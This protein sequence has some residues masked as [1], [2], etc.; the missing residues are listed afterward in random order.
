MT[1][2]INEDTGLFEATDSRGNIY[3]Q[4][5][6]DHY[7]CALP[8]GR[9]SYGRSAAEARVKAEKS[10]IQI[11][12]NISGKHA[13][14]IGRLAREED[15]TASKLVEDLVRVMLERRGPFSPDMISF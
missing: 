12:F 14:I 9:E 6:A 5:K 11:R 7:H 10:A 13:E 8:D 3:H 2:E 4:F 15:K 1:F